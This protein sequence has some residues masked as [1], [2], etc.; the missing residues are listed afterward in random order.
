MG[1]I[2]EGYYKFCAVFLHYRPISLSIN[3]TWVSLIP[4][5]NN[6]R[7]I[8]DYRPISVVGSMYKIISKLIANR[9]KCVIG[10]VVSD[11]QLG[12]IKG[13]Y[14]FDGILNANEALH[15]LKKKKK[16]GTLFKVDFKRAYD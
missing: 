16:K 12:F 2:R 7:S 3:N 10:E 8:E 9:I 6:P 15:W 5:K 14:I 4:K 1:S 13:R 11:T